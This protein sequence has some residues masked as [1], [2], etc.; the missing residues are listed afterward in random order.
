[1]WFNSSDHPS[2]T[3]NRLRRRRFST[4]K[5]NINVINKS[6]YYCTFCS[7][8]EE[9]KE[10]DHLSSPPPPP[11]SPPLS[12]QQQIM[13]SSTLTPLI[14]PPPQYFSKRRTSKCSNM[15]EFTTSNPTIP[16]Q[17]FMAL[18]RRR[19]S[20]ASEVSNVEIQK[21]TENVYRLYEL[22]VDEVI[23]FFFF[24]L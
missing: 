20:N 17:Q 15:S 5:S 6:T 14:P 23:I 2:R 13:G 7:N 16:G 24:I 10:T 3:N 4:A 12:Q 19:A 22:A 8:H 1:M 9:E 11:S 18:F 21:E